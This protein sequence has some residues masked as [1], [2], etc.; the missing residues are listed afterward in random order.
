[1]EVWVESFQFP[2]HSISNLGRVRNDDRDL[3]LANRI[4]AS[5]HVAVSITKDGVQRSRSLSKLVADCF[6]LG[7][8]EIF[9]T[10]IHLDG[11]HKNC[12]AANLMWRPRWF[13]FKYH[14]QFT[15]NFPKHPPL[16]REETGEVYKS[17]WEM[18]TTEGL[19]YY[20]I[21]QSAASGA[22]VFPINHHFSFKS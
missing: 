6:V 19:L 9:N 2:G 18:V 12:S 21:L 15:V 5:G 22:A 17:A 4:L 16:V 13:S 14:G 7:Y 3:V 11:D 1:M 10:P 20:Q 8:S